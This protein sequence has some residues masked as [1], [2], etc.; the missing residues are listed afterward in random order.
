MHTSYLREEEKTVVNAIEKA[1]DTL[2]AER[3]AAYLDGKNEGR[4]EGRSEGL[5]EAEKQ[6][7]ADKRIRVLNMKAD[8]LPVELISKYANMP[9]DA[10]RDI[11]SG[12]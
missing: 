6:I 2:Q 9:L 5:M 1:R 12:A 4:M 8:G 7:L 3:Y 10:V 11:V